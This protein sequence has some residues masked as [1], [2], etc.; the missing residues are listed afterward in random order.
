MHYDDFTAADYAADVAGGRY[1]DA[2]EYL[3]YRCYAYPLLDDSEP[4]F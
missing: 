4:A 3:A 2:T 1:A